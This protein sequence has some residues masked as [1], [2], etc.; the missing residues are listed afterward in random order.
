MPLKTPKFWYQKTIGVKAA[1]LLPFSWLYGFG[2]L[3]HCLVVKPVSLEDVHIICVGNVNVGGSG[4]TP[5]SIALMQLI[6]QH[7]LARYPAFL[8]RGYGVKNDAPMRVD[9][10]EHDA[11]DVGEEALLLAR[12]GDVYVSADRKAGAMAARADGVDVILMDDG[13]QNRSLKPDTSFIVVDGRMRFGNQQIMPAGPLREGLKSALRRVDGCIA[14]DCDDLPE[15]G[16]APRF[17][18]HVQ[19]HDGA[20]PDR[21]LNYFAFAGIGYPEKFF[22]YLRVL[23]LSVAAQKAFADHHAYSRADLQNIL[24][25]ANVSNMRLITTEKDYMHIKPLLKQGEEVAVLPISVIFDQ[26]ENLVDWLR[27]RIKL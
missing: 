24:R 8:L 19:T 12:Y 14:I 21:S 4:K 9:L 20:V 16:D 25:Q 15:I 11:S 6:K 23:G 1:L 27:E 13:L 2:R 22:D 7:N 26:S 18:G 5:T 10:N 3:L 17:D